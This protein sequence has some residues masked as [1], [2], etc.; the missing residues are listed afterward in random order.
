MNDAPA[1]AGDA[2]SNAW[3]FSQADED[4]SSAPPAA[5]RSGRPWAPS[6]DW[7]RLRDWAERLSEPQAWGADAWRAVGLAL[8]V[9]PDWSGPWLEVEVRGHRHAY[10]SA[11]MSPERVRLIQGEHPRQ[12]A[13]DRAGTD[14]R[15]WFSGGDAFLEALVMGLR[16][17][18]GSSAV[19]WEATQ[20]RAEVSRLLR[21]ALVPP[22]GATR[23]APW[24]DELLQQPPEPLTGM[25]PA[26]RPARAV[27]VGPM[28]GR[29][30]TVDPPSGPAAAIMPVPEH[31]EASMV[32]LAAAQG[33][34]SSAG[35]PVVSRTEAPTY[36]NEPEIRLA[37]RRARHE[38]ARNDLDAACRVVEGIRPRYKTPLM[39]VGLLCDAAV[40]TGFNSRGIRLL[41]RLASGP[42]PMFDRELGYQRARDTLDF[43]YASLLT[44]ETVPLSA[45]SEHPGDVGLT[46]ARRD[47]LRVIHRNGAAPRSL[48]TLI[49]DLHQRRGNLRPGTHIVVGEHGAGHLRRTMLNCLSECGWRWQPALYL[50]TKAELRGLIVIAP[51]DGQLTEEQRWPRA[52]CYDE[53]MF[54]QALA[55]AATSR[56][57]DVTLP[58]DRPL[59]KV[60]HEAYRRLGLP[61]LLAMLEAQPQLPVILYEYLFQNAV[62][63]GDLRDVEQALAATLNRFRPLTDATWQALLQSVRNTKTER[64]KW[65]KLVALAA[66]L[67]REHVCLTEPLTALMLTCVHSSRQLGALVPMIHA[68]FHNGHPESVPVRLAV[69]KTAAR[70]ADKWRWQRELTQ[71]G[72]PQSEAF[73][74]ICDH[75]VL[76]VSQVRS[77][78]EGLRLHDRL[79]E[80]GV[81]F[82]REVIMGV[83]SLLRQERRW[84][85]AAALMRASVDSADGVYEPR[86]GLDE[87]AQPTILRLHRTRLLSTSQ[88]GP[89]G[90]LLSIVECMAIVA[91]HR[92]SQRLPVGT[93]VDLGDGL[94]AINEPGIRRMLAQMGIKLIPSQCG[95][96]GTVILWQVADLDDNTRRP[97]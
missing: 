37:L 33:A 63:L 85:Q 18:Q 7:S 82:G 34:A 31:R 93:R 43:H 5:A 10:I 83:L 28:G 14:E 49:F 35:D 92:V 17:T 44:P 60:Q 19:G 86:L 30:A 39:L 53:V 80:C 74:A 42:E 22:R 84:P 59:L 68:S 27:F 11:G 41:E 25:S 8:L 55:A 73:Q 4:Q 67:Q 52:W 88:S 54:A 36:L 48:A 56:V 81:R 21:D 94:A 78:N 97:A 12:W 23:P 29:S 91:L 40:Q 26:I 47:A 9:M 75:E 46:V 15:H 96:D 62:Q 58:G 13:A 79:R 71:L 50:G 51:P 6:S 20:W 16:Q 69:M 77:T 3:R 1:V 65:P 64:Q 87:T 32:S 45:C 24:L 89:P 57:E 72:G 66:A 61:R 95:A 76:L 90:A 70:I 2:R 38:L